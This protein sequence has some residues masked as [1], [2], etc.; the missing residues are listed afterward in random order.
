MTR[1]EPDLHAT[2]SAIYESGIDPASRE[3]CLD[4]IIDFC[5]AERG[6]MGLFDVAQRAIYVGV[7]R[8]IDPEYLIRF[9]RDYG[10]QDPFYEEDEFFL[11]PGTVKHAASLRDQAKLRAMPIYRE[12]LVPSGVIDDITVVLSASEGF[13]SFLSVFRGE[14]AGVFDEASVAAMATLAPHFVRSRRIDLIL[15]AQE[16]RRFVTEG[17][18]DQLGTS[19]VVIDVAGHVEFTNRAAEE[20]LSEAD[21]I[22]V[23]DGELRCDRA[24]AST[25]LR[26]HVQESLEHAAGEREVAGGVVPIHRPSGRR[27][28][29]ALVTPMAPR[30]GRSLGLSRYEGPAAIVV[31]SEP[32]RAEDSP[33]KLLREL[34][35]LTSAE[36]R[37]VW[38]LA[39]GLSPEEHADEAG[40]ALSTVRGQL[41]EAYSK[42]D[43]R[44]QAELVSLVLRS[45]GP[46]RL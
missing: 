35:D 15:T 21:G 3:D 46:F 39:R 34:F 25:A 26:R 18:L 4:L 44:R 12:L 28:L 14:E 6:M 19:L 38:A 40:V 41:K 30:L 36:A 24:D 33:E 10:A 20:L 17:A 13:Y 23:S 43:T 27:S 31:L 22:R 45:L 42:T 9:A 16:R 8:G 29:R 1:R 32:G 7:A 37:V 11:E 5:G 2:I